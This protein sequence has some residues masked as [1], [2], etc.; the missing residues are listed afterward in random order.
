M[1]IAAGVLCLVL[2]AWL[3]LAGLCNGRAMVD[4]LDH[5]LIRE[6]VGRGMARWVWLLLGVGGITG[7]ILLI[8]T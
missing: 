3:L 5:G 4:L 8:V 1:G 6:S 2:G 7:G